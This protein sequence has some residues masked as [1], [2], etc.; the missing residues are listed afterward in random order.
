MSKARKTVILWVV[1][2]ILFVAFYQFFSVP[3]DPNA[4]AAPHEPGLDWSLILMQWAPFAVLFV[5]FVLFLNA[6]QKKFVP[7][8][9]GVKLLHQGRYVKA[10][11]VFEKF[12]KDYPKLALGPFNAGSTRMQLW[13][14]EAALGD[15]EAAQKLGAG[16]LKEMVA[17]LPEHLALT[18]ALLGRTGDAR[19]RLNE[20]PAGQGDPA[21]VAVAEAILFLR[22]GEAAR[23]REKLNT[24]EVKQL[25][26]TIGALARTL[27]ALCIEQLTGELRHVDRVALFGATGPEDLRKAWPELIAFVERAPEW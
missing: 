23:A 16:K 1:L 18:H 8:N 22:A 10:L 12:S 9:E 6:R 4:A 14:L 24:F 25:A 3:P 11:E 27:D 17:L 21:R 15:F 20:V 26:G 2:I 13:R 19:R 5:G 7:N